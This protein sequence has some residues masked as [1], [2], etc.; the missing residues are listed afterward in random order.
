[1]NK[2]ISL[3]KIITKYEKLHKL[4]IKLIKQ[5]PFCVVYRRAAGGSVKFDMV[6]GLTGKRGGTLANQAFLAA[7]Y[8]GNPGHH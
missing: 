6:D 1:M 3:K 8:E 7:L 4:C 5:Y 2:N